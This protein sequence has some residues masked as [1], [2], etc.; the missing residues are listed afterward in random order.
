MVSDVINSGTG[1]NCASEF[2][3]PRMLKGD[4][5]AGFD[6]GSLQ[7]SHQ[8]YRDIRE[9]LHSRAGSKRRTRWHF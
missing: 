5:S 1:K 4:F 6:E 8:R 9:S 7:G 3:I 2:F